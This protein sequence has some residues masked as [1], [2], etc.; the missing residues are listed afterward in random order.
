MLLNI[1][2]LS[3]VEQIVLI[4]LNELTPIDTNNYRL[5]VSKRFGGS[6]DQTKASQQVMKTDFES[7]SIYHAQ[8]VMG[9][10]VWLL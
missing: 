8:L 3:K 6:R 10:H 9:I 2:L 7:Q 4:L 1:R 5:A